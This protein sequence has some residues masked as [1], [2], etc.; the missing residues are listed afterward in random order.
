MYINDITILGNL[1][2]KPE[3]K[4]TASGVSY[5]IMSIITE[6][7]VKDKATN[8]YVPKTK[9]HLVKCWAKLAENVSTHF[10]KGEIVCVKGHIEDETWKDANGSDQ[11]M[12]IILPHGNDFNSVQRIPSK[13]E[14]VK[15]NQPTSNKSFKNATE[16][17]FSI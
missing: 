13:K 5:C 4:T 17:R 1:T 2:K 7:D 15:I 12:T 3:L 16:V 11:T 6:R 9:L 8:E 14:S 10:N